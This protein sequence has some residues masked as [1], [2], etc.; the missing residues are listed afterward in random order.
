MHLQKILYQNMKN[1][2]KDE[3]ITLKDID[4]LCERAA[5]VI[6]LSVDNILKTKKEVVLGI[7]GGRS[8]PGIFYRLKNMDLPWE[9]IHIFM[10]DE[11]IVPIEHKDSNFRLAKEKFISVL[12]SK[13]MI[14][15]ANVHPFIK[16]EFKKES[17][18]NDY[19]KEL[20]EF[21]SGFDIII[22][23]SGEDGHVGALYPDH[24]SIL[25]KRSA[26][27]TMDDSPKL[28]PNRMTASKHLMQTAKTSI[29]IFLG[30]AKKD[31]LLKFKDDNVKV[32]HCPVKL[33]KEIEDS[34]V[35]TDIILD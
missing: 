15:R 34:H 1:S 14:P 21:G 8:V 27:I 16:N 26:F 4:E 22:L 7:V 5:D 12:V 28:P 11:R 23:S 3:V 2:N 25:D 32:E 19:T 29:L 33:V 9:N 13:G 31:A 17:G 24:D 20:Q 35:F 6:K 18:A 30:E 10:V